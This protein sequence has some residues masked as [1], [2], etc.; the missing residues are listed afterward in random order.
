MCLL[1][2]SGEKITYYTGDVYDVGQ[3]WVEVGASVTWYN[4][5]VRACHDAIVYLSHER[6]AASDSAYEI[7][8]GTKNNLRTQIRRA[9]DRQVLADEDTPDIV[10]C[11]N[12]RQFWVS[13]V[14]G[15]LQMGT[16]GLKDINKVISHDTADTRTIRS[17]AMTGD[18]LQ[19]DP[20]RWEVRKNS[21]KS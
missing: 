4:F 14:E 19:G 3:L 5:R 8:I 17:V 2:T 1:F 6:M 20:A 18:N 15:L 9:S 13:W 21:G 16:G 7:A 10:N 11:S 12:Y